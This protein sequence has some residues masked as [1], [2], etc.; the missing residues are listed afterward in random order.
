MA[1]NIFAVDDLVNLVRSGLPLPAPLPPIVRGTFAD[2][3]SRQAEW[4]SFFLDKKDSLELVPD[5]RAYCTDPQLCVVYAAKGAMSFLFRSADGS[6][7]CW[8]FASSLS[9]AC[10]VLQSETQEINRMVQQYRLA[11]PFRNMALQRFT[12]VV[13]LAAVMERL[14][15]CPIVGNVPRTETFLKWA[16][17]ALKSGQNGFIEDG[18]R[19]ASL[20]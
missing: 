5:P 15:F 12:E 16:I 17:E 7:Y 3:L 19:Y 20:H 10:N 9:H 18:V 8:E 4:S 2:W 13:R 14:R 11:N 1:S 6:R